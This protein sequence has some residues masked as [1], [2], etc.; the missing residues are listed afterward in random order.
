MET[1]FGSANS[2]TLSFDS[3]I[4]KGAD[5]MKTLRI[6][7][8]FAIGL[9]ALTLSACAEHALIA[10]QNPS[11][12]Q[13]MTLSEP[14][15][16][17]DVF[18]ARGGFLKPSASQNFLFVSDDGSNSV[19]LL[20]PTQPGMPPVGQITDGVNGPGG[21]TTDSRGTLYVTN[22]GA[23]P[24]SLTEYPAGH[25][26][27]SVLLANGITIP[28]A[29]VVDSQRTVYVSNPFASPP[30]V[31][32]YKVGQ[33]SPFETITG[34]S[35]PIGLAVDKLNTLYVDDLRSGVWV[36]PFDSSTPTN[37]NLQDLVNPTSIAVG[38][39]GVLSVS[40]I[41]GGT[42]PARILRY[43][44]G[45]TVPFA[46]ITDNVYNPQFITYAHALRTL[47]VNMHGGGGGYEAGFRDDQRKA[48][49]WGFDPSAGSGL[50]FSTNVKW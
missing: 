7:Q 30:N 23:S 44:Q 33:L 43:A 22:E 12:I 26:H 18:K 40:D 15:R 25:L 8:Y 20:D 11:V 45:S 49:V 48:Y 32:A 46:I 35:D 37:L 39:G 50:A 6:C 1:Q 14:G 41:G 27:P 38:A 17:V 9:A 31:V 36:V 2:G 13:S 28:W 29:V 4:H 42:T 5:Y 34:F 24:G 10:P 3:I 19:F 47:F 16:S 21:L